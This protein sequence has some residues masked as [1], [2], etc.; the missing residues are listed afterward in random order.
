MHDSYGFDQIYKINKDL[1]NP[2]LYAHS[3]NAFF[4]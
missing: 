3:Y 1:D 4:D 2:I